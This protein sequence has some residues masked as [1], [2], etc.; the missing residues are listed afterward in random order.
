MKVNISL[1][2]DSSLFAI[3]IV[4]CLYHM[5]FEINIDRIYIYGD[6]PDG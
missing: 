5:Y 1:V 2:E 6:R 3:Y 4:Y